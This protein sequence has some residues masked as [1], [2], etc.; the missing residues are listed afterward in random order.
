MRD[1]LRSGAESSQAQTCDQRDDLGSRLRDLA[2]LLAW[3]N[4]AI[5]EKCWN[6]E[7]LAAHMQ[8]DRAYISRV[9]SGDKPLSAAFLRALPDD[10]E[11]AV[12][13][14]YAESFGLVVVAPASGDQAVRNLVSG[15]VGM[16]SAPA[17]PAK[18]DRM[19]R[20]ELPTRKVAAR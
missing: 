6:H 13:S 11:A 15:L 19:V 1:S 20:S 17:L 12:A 18:A 3:I 7:A 14:Y 9:L 4:R 5:D 10:I 2:E 8:K 16:L